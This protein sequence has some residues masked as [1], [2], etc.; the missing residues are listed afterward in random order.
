MGPGERRWVSEL[1]AGGLLRA[2]VAARGCRVADEVPSVPV[3]GGVG[4]RGSAVRAGRTEVFVVSALPLFEARAWAIARHGDQRYGAYP[5]S[6]HLDEVVAVLRQYD[7]DDEEVIAAGYL[8]DVLEDTSATREEVESAFG[9]GVATIVQVVTLPRPAPAFARPDGDARE[10]TKA[11][12][13]DRMYALIDAVG[14]RAKVVKVADRIAN[15]AA[16]Q[17]YSFNEEK[18]RRYLAEWPR[19][20]EA[21]G[22]PWDG[23]PFGMWKRLDVLFGG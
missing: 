13:L 14:P 18:Y 15:V 11:E 23:V 12:R 20:A 8:H 21:L 16:C 2:A 10:E 4:A 22:R 17:G 5:Y 19:F 9:Q 6:R 3:D 1:P 7:I